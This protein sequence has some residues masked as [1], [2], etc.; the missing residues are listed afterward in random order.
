M[1]L[2]K[3]KKRFS[4]GDTCFASHTAIT[5]CIVFSCSSISSN[6]VVQVQGSRKYIMSIR[7]PRHRWNVKHPKAAISRIFKHNI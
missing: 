4:S 3:V 7:Y 1:E 5:L 6:P 2:S